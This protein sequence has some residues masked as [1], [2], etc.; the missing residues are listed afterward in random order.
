MKTTEK[1]KSLNIQPKNTRSNRGVSITSATSV[2]QPKLK[3]GAPNDKY[4]QEADRMAD[5]VTSA[6]TPTFASTSD[7]VGGIQRKCA[8]CEKEELQRKPLSQ[9]ITPLV[10]RQ[11]MEEEDDLEGQPTSDIGVQRMSLDDDEDINIH[12]KGDGEVSASP[13]LESQLS[14]SKGGGNPLPDTTRQSMESG[15][16]ADFS[17]VRIHTD[18]QAIQMSQDINAQ[19]FTN[20]S[21]VYFNQG[22]YSPNSSEGKHLL[23]HELTHVVQQ[24]GQQ[25]RDIQTKRLLDFK[26]AKNFSPSDEQIQETNEYKAYTNERLVWQTEEGLKPTKDE[27]ILATRLILIDM[28]IKKINWK[29]EARK[30]LLKAFQISRDLTQNLDTTSENPGIENVQSLAKNSFNTIEELRRNRT[31]HAVIGFLTRHPDFKPLSFEDRQKIVDFLTKVEPENPNEALVK[32]QKSEEDLTGLS[33][34]MPFDINLSEDLFLT[35]E[36]RKNPKFSTSKLLNNPLE[37]VKNG[38]VRISVTKK[39]DFSKAKKEDSSNINFSECNFHWRQKARSSLKKASSVISAINPILKKQDKASLTDKNS[40]AGHLINYHFH[41]RDIKDLKQIIS[42]YQ[43]I[44]NALGR[45][46]DIECVNERCVDSEGREQIAFVKR[47][48]IFNISTWFGGDKKIYL[49][50]AWAK[51]KSFEETVNTM[52]HEIAHA[53][54]GVN[55]KETYMNVDLA[56]YQNLT[57]NEALQ[58][59]DSYSR[60]AL[61]MMRNKDRK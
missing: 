38:E 9:L 17:N 8:A 28:A 59:A 44:Q 55:G 43:K 22:K 6:P 20:G 16:G 12:R 3:I 35:I 18:S 30:Y 56:K 26:K 45:E 41:T 47:F 34:L 5:L 1:P 24:S 23:A 2:L 40:V 37:L 31:L 21:D 57:A 11:S 27:A 52:I 61:E 10:Q 4:E 7:E 14:S 15:F 54:G 58:N 53:F 51:Q 49:C 42:V 32:N 60:F 50:S 25:A 19:A 29:H 48:W 46:I 33:T 39:I 36:A 13:N